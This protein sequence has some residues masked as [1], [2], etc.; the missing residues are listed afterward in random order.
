MKHFFLSVAGV[1]VVVLA[2][3]QKIKEVEKAYILQ[4]FE[5]AKTEVDKVAADAKQ[6]SNPETWFW[7]ASVYSALYDDAALSAKYPFAGE[8]AMSSFKKYTQIDPA[9]KVM[10]ASAHPGK[11]VVDMLYRGNLKQGIGFFDKKQ[12]DSAYKYFGRS[13]DIGDLI[14]ANDW[15][16][17]KQPIDTITVLF[18]G[19]AAQN[20]KKAADAA[21][22]YARIADLKITNVPAAGDIKDVYE[23]LVYHYMDTKNAALFNKYVTIAKQV[24]PKEINTWADYESEFVEKNFSLEEKVA[25]YDKADAAGTL[26]S[27]QYLSYG[28]MFYNLK[29]EEK[30]KLDSLQKRTY[31]N[32]AEQAFTKAYQKDNTSGIAAF[33]AGLL[34]Y[35]DWVDLDEQYSTNVRKMGELNRSVANEKDPKKKAALQAKVKKDVDAL[36]AINA[37]IEKQQHAYVNKAAEWSERS[38]N[39]LG[40]KCMLDRSEQNVFGKSADY[41]T[42]LYGWKRDKSKGNAGEY[43]KYDALY[44]KYDVVH[45][46]SGTAAQEKF[47]KIK[48]RMKK[49]DV[50]AAIGDPSEQ[51]VSTS[52]EGKFEV[53]AYDSANGCKITIQIN[54]KGEVAS[55]SSNK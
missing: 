52:K 3:A 32:K 23:Y 54:E 38:F 22:Y 27:N 20:S 2:S 55:I 9:Y 29:D 18:T 46:M 53:L 43:D 50:I 1:L 28:N 33:N 41:L 14:T 39:A 11:L 30:E 42:N 19:Y 13:A 17:N 45:G 16:G 21:K 44:K 36:K 24:Y 40:A 37:G 7:H 34:N 31:R 12:W 5:D 51:S 35:N 26:T 49:A 47:N 48:L 4:K 8:V 6:Q 10:I 25:A 15:K